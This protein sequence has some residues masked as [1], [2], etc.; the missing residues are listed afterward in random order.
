MHHTYHNETIEDLKWGIRLW[1][2]NR[3][4]INAGFI[5]QMI[6]RRLKVLRERTRQ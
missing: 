3:H 4:G 5:R 1:W 6:R 2:R